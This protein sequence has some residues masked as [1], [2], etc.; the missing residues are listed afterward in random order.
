MKERNNSSTLVMMFDKP[1][2]LFAL[3]GLVACYSTSHTPLSKSASSLPMRDAVFAEVKGPVGRWTI[4][5][6][7]EMQQFLT[8]FDEKPLNS[9]GSTIGMPFFSIR[10]LKPD[11]SILNV[12]IGSM[13]WETKGARGAMAEGWHSYFYDASNY[14]PSIE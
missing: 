8:Y 9:T 13:T 10:F 4:N 14:D 7:E 3:L 12:Y 2:F 5:A 6:G 11:G 1:L